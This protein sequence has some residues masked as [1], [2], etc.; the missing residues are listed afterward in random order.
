MSG[1]TFWIVLFGSNLGCV[2]LGFLF[3]RLTR[4]A[5]QVEQRM[6][7]VTEDSPPPKP[8]RHRGP[9]ALHVISLA[10]VFIGVVT[11]VVGFGVTQNQDRLT[12]CVVEYSNATAD[13]LTASRAAQRVVNEQIDGFMKAILDAF[14]S[15]PEEGRKAVLESVQDYLDARAEQ[16]K[17]QRENPLP[18]A[19][20]DA[21]AELLD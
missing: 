2:C 10:V 18:E 4:A 8:A 21:C 19:P 1:M 14:N 5:V 9:T 20:R 7:D 13:A 16:V 12:G 15:L 17:V 11:A 6:V 3:G